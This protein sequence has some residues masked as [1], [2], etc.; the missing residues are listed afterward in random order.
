MDAPEV[1]RIQCRSLFNALA[2]GTISGILRAYNGHVAEVNG[3][4]SRSLVVTRGHTKTLANKGFWGYF[5]EHPQRDSNPCR[6]L[7]RV[8]S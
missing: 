1:K 8:V 2:S 7:E 3:G 5:L 4:H 6:H